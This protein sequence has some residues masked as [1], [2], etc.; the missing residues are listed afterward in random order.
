MTDLTGK[1]I[2]HLRGL[3]HGLHPHVLIAAAPLSETLWKEL[4]HQIDHHELIKVKAAIDER[5]ERHRLFAEIADKLHAGFV[6]ELGK[7]ALYYRP[8]P[9]KKKPIEL[10]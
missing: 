10:P 2:R 4:E 7:T 8:N 5:E 6:Q 9:K 3:G 1:Q